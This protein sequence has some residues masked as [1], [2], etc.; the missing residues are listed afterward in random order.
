L[1]QPGEVAIWVDAVSAAGFDQ[2]VEIGT[3]VRAVNSV[4]EE[5]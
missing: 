2:R 3:R 4:G 5:P 1:E